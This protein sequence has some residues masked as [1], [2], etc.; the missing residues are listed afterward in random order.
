[1]KPRVSVVIPLYNKRLSVER[2]VRSVLAQTESD[3]ELIIVNDGSTDGS[4]HVVAAIGDRRIRLVS[5]ANGGESAARNTGISIATADLVAFLDADDEWFP[6]FLETVLALAIRF[7]DAGA[8]A[9]SFFACLDG[10]ISRYKYIGV[11]FVRSGEI[12][13]SYF[14]SCTLGSSIV[15]SSSVMIPRKVFD[16]VGNFTIGARNGADLDMWA[17]IALRFPIAWS[18]VETAIWHQSAENR[19]AGMVVMD[20]VPFSG[21]LLDALASGRY[22]LDQQ[23]W[24]REYLNKFRIILAITCLN[25]GA[26]GNARRLLIRTARTKLFRGLWLSAVTRAWCP[27]KVGLLASRAVWAVARQMGATS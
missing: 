19:C 20:D 16:T 22:D 6:H 7:P 21:V 13:D 10:R 2:A 17:R 24:I 14:R 15:W 3:F 25:Q 26:V 8:Y 12:V 11:R 4:E 1:M 5:Q 23:F 18:P 27:S 9:V